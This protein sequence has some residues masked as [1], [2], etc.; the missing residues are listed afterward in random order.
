MQLNAQS[1]Q[2]GTIG[3]AVAPAEPTTFITPLVFASGNLRQMVERLRR[4]SDRLVGPL[5]PATGLGSAGKPA[6]EAVFDEV[7]E[8]AEAINQMISEV[9]EMLS[10]I[11]RALP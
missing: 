6:S 2:F 4:V 7:R 10:R 11:E 9:D 8:R 1:N 5:P 3:S